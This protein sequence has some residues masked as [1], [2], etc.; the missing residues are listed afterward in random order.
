MDFRRLD[1]IIKGWFRS[2]KCWAIVDGC[3]YREVYKNK[4]LQVLRC[5]HC[6]REDVGWFGSAYSRKD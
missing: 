2:L 4:D 5:E 1:C 6:D 3:T